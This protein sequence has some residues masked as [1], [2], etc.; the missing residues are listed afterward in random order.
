MPD[1]PFWVRILALLTLMAIVAGADAWVRRRQ[2]RRWKEYLFILAVGC[3]GAVFG[4]MT[5][6]VTSSISADY[7]IFGKELSPDGIRWRAMLLG[8]QAGFSA[9][10]IAG[11][12]C[13]FIGLQ[14]RTGSMTLPKVGL[15]AWRPLVLAPVLGVA[16][17]L[18]C[19]WFDPYRFVESLGRTSIGP[20][21][22]VRFLTV[23]HIHLGV[24]LGLGVG[25]VWMIVEL[26]RLTA[27]DA[28]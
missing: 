28:K 9:G 20:D 10:A 25:V 26:R 8:L 21:R 2:A 3:L 27:N 22:A 13:L 14:N 5:D 4:A 1:I 24:Y 23:W 19:S 15:L 6:F 16:V 7:F 12:L 11:A 17:P 18:T